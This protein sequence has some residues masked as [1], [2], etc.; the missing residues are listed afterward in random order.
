METAF[1]PISAAFGGV[2]IGLAATL[3]MLTLGRIAGVT[4]ILV[5]LFFASDLRDWAWRAAVVA[6]LITAPVL[7]T[8]ATSQTPVVTIPVSS[9]ALIG[10]GLMVG[11]GVVLGSGCTSGHGVCG[12][13]R[14][15]LR[16]LVATFTFMISAAV[17]VAIVRHVLGG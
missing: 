8:L 15:S 12:L 4:G 6:G 1:T 5:G 17:T 2:L 3:L 7:I 16:S 14:F 9:P 10:G 11:A 13:A